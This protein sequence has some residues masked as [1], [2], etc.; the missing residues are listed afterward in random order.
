[1][2]KVAK[3]VAA[4]LMTRVI[5]DESATDEEIMEAARPHFAEKVATELME[6][7]E[8][9]EDDTEC[10]YGTLNDER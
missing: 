5:V 1:M 3:L 4:N 7:Y 10:P 2:G 6:N 8:F 9:I